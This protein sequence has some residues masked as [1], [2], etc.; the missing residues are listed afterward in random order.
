M[1]FYKT[2]P[3]I[4]IEIAPAHILA[5]LVS[6]S[7]KSWVLNQC[8]N[9]RM[10]ELTLKPSFKTENILNPDHF[11]SALEKVLQACQTLKG[12]VNVSLPN[13]VAKIVVRQF[14]D[15]P[16]DNREKN[17]RIRWSVSKSL[18]F[19]L[20]DLRVSWNVMGT[21]SNGMTVIVAAMACDSVLSQYESEIRQ[22][23]IV[24]SILSP[25]GLNQFNFYSHAIPDKGRIAYLGLFEEFITVF[26]FDDGV[27]FFY[28]TI[29]KG[30]LS[31]NGV[32]TFDDLDVVLQYYMNEYPDLILEKI[33]IAP[34]R[35]SQYLMTENIAPD[36]IDFIFLNETDCMEIGKNAGVNT[37]NGALALFAGAAGVAKS[38]AVYG[39]QKGVC[40]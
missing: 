33:F 7:G 40:P 35:Q 34:H 2:R 24:P 5:A 38:G 18:D 8:A 19:P 13:G 31:T 26:I 10:P 28:K 23:G 1:L 12:N 16:R 25:T 11:R 21:D 36:G 37:N 4:G 15:L 32:N 27:P 17:E 29:K 22:V 6:R 20:D 14:E 30:F 3:H 39:R 9:T